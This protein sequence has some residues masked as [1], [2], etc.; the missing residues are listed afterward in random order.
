MRTVRRPEAANGAPPAVSQ[1]ADAASVTSR[2]GSP[3][4]SAA[5]TAFTRAPLARRQP[6]GGASR[7][8]PSAVSPAVVIAARVPRA[9]AMVRASRL[10]P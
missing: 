2:T 3:A 1:S 9:A 7:A 10:A 8:K 4:S 6:A 5:V